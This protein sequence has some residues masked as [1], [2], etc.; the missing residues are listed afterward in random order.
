MQNVMQVKNYVHCDAI[1][2]LNKWIQI[3][4]C[5]RRQA[6]YTF[7]LSTTQP[8]NKNGKILPADYKMSVSDNIS[9]YQEMIVIRLS[10]TKKITSSF[11]EV[12]MIKF[13]RIV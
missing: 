12:L 8:S 3:E 2:N 9:C 11:V 5:L 6:N 1:A 4:H 13:I 7:T 10:L